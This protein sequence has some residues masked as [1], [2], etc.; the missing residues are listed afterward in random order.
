MLQGLKVRDIRAEEFC[1]D[2]A[3]DDYVPAESFEK[4]HAWP[5]P[6]LGYKVVDLF[7]E[8]MEDGALMDLIDCRASNINGFSASIR[9]GGFSLAALL[10]DPHCDLGHSRQ[11]SRL[12]NSLNTATWMHMP[13]DQGE[14]VEDIWLVTSRIAR[15]GRRRKQLASGLMVRCGLLPYFASTYSLS[16]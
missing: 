1:N 8:E 5:S 2:S 11:R 14:Y 12:Y 13:I 10:V 4:P 6:C 9:G 7:G 15:R 16:L 3:S